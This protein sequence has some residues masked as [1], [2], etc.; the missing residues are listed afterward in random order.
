MTLK[1]ELEN[2]R[3]RSLLRRRRSVESACGPEVTVEGRTVLAFASNDYLGLAADP[4][5]I[6]AAREGA[7]RYG[8]GAGASHLISG[9]YAPHQALEEQLAAFV[10][11]ERALYFSTG[12]MANLGAVTS[13]AGGNDAVFSDQLNHA[14]LIDGIRLSGAEKH[15]YP[16]RDLAALEAMLRTCSAAN[17]LVVS[18]A[19]FGMD[20]DLAPLPELLELCER[21]DARLLVDDA[22]GFGVQGPQG[23]GSLAKFGIA[24]PR[25]VYIG[26]LGKAAGV[27]GAFAAGSDEVI[28]WLLQSARTYIFTTGAPPLL[29]HALLASVDLIERGDHRRAHLARL[30]AQLRAGLKLKRWQLSDSTTAIQPLIIGTNEEALRIGARLYESGLWIPVIR[31]PTVPEGTSRLRISLSAAHTPAQVERLVTTL[32]ELE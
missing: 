25:I 17:K 11:M 14:S 12:F 15:I 28:E 26:T 3:E 23:R 13:L 29:A 9:H 24:S 22:H 2:L 30:I 6:E 27:S 18:D 10:G 4:A 8:V 32:N 19:V 20:G 1:D 16:H 7:G 31:P 5:L 21:H